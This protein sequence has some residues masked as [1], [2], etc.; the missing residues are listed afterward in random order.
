[1]LS[2]LFL[3]YLTREKKRKRKR[4]RTKGRNREKERDRLIRYRM[5]R[6]DRYAVFMRIY[7]RTFSGC[8]G[9]EEAKFNSDRIRRGA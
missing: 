5:I 2:F 7:M 1:M 8:S 9:E 3:S 6:P 4:N